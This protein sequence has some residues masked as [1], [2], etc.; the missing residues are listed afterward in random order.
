VAA[1]ETDARQ[2]RDQLREIMN[3][4]PP[5]LGRILRMD[6][7]LLRDQAYLSRYPAVAAFLSTH[8]EI[9]NNPDFYLAFVRDFGD[10]TMPT[11]AR[12]SA[13]SMW[14]N[15]IEGISI[16]T[17]V[18]FI[19]GLFAWLV[20]TGL[21]HRRWLRVTR[22][23][24]EV[25]NKLLDRFASTGELLSYVQTPAGRRFLEAAPIPLDGP[26]PKPANQTAPISRILWSVQAG[27]V[28]VVGGI[29][30]QFVSGRI[31][32]EVAE[33][34]WMI[35]VLGIAFGIGFILS[36]AISYLLSRRLGLLE[37]A[38]VAPLTGRGDTTAV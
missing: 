24:T 37:P 33:G 31:I 38:P 12:T 26:G 10:Y 36:G 30:F 5:E 34:L 28:M 17:V 27:V 7:T 23:Q 8:P 1:L 9:P 4:Y 2:V 11:D 13:I 35:G 32:E 22:V 16:F 21:D 18:V 29:G 25:H 19:G 15:L 3:R 14:R 6:P 20:R